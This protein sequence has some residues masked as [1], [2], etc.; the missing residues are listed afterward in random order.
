MR[1]NIGKIGN[2][3]KIGN[4]R[5]IGKNKKYKLRNEDLLPRFSEQF[6]MKSIIMLYSF[7]K[8][9]S[10]LPSIVP[11]KSANFLYSKSNNMN[12]FSNFTEF[13]YF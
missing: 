8:T 4:I 9:S 6:F 3:D 1:G 5:K 11:S 13:Y 12:F 7:M 10:N 2:I